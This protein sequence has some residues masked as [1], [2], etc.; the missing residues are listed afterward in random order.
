MVERQS[1]CSG[2]KYIRHSQVKCILCSKK[3]KILAFVVNSRKLPD[4]RSVLRPFIEIPD[5]DFRK[6]LP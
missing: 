3:P 1:A 4:G 6:I 5:A 2:S